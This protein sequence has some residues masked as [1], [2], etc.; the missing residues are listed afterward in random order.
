MNQETD[1]QFPVEKRSSTMNTSNFGI[2]THCF[3]AFAV[4]CA[5]VATPSAAQTY[6][7]DFE[8]LSDPLTEL[9][10]W[11]IPVTETTSTS[12]PRTFLGRFCNDT[13]SLTFPSI[14]ACEVMVS[15]DLF[16]IQSWD[17]HGDFDG[18]TGPD[19][20]DLAVDNGPTL[21]TTTFATHDPR[22]QAYPN[23]YIAQGAD[24]LFPPH[25]GAEEI[26][27][28]GFPDF[29]GSGDVYS[30]S[31]QFSHLGGDLILYFSAFNLQDIEDESWGLDN[32]VVNRLPDCSNATPSVDTLWPVNHKFVPVNIMGVTDP[33]GDPVTITIT[34]IFQDEPVNVEGSGSTEP[35]G[36]G[37]GTDTAEVRA[38]RSGTKK[39]PGNGRVYHIS[40]IAADGVGGF[41]DGTVTVCVPHDQSGDPCVDEGALYDSTVP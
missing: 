24:P 5:L 20:W 9:T 32:V 40:F 34:S 28:L 19:I 30:M 1:V 6:F 38:E 31:F 7:N 29:F 4:G 35:D 10:E 12:T 25:Q 13:V 8:G 16:I 33:D 14:S 23:W 2:K 39:V 17:G 41:C 11:S 18:A 37:V 3:L 27:S 15:F 26:N 22:K 36:Q 21:L